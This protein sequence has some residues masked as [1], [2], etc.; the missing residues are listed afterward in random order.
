MKIFK[1]P[2]EIIDRQAIQV[3]AGSTILSVK[4]QYDTAVMYVLCDEERTDSLLLDI[5]V[6]GTG[7]IIDFDVNEYT[8]IDTISTNGGTYMWHVFARNNDN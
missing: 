6:V 2:I 5:Q 7:N 3:I 4:N 1:Y 8:F